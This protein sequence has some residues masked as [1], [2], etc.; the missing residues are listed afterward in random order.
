MSLNVFGSPKSS[1][2]SLSKQLKNEGDTSSSKRGFGTA[3]IWI[4]A[5][6][7]NHSCLGNCRR[8]FIGDM[9]IVRALVDMEE[10]TELRFSYHP[11]T[12]LESYDDV[13]RAL[14]HWGFSCDCALCR[15]RRATPAE[16]IRKR[17]SL[18][19]TLK[20]VL[21]AQNTKLAKASKLL[22]EIKATYPT[23][24]PDELPRLEM[25]SPYFAMSVAYYRKGSIAKAAEMLLE[26]LHALCYNIA[27][28]WR[29]DKTADGE[30]KAQFEIKR[31]GMAMD[32]VPWAFVNLHGIAKSLAPS[33]CPQILE[34]AERAYSMIVGERGSFKQTFP[35][36]M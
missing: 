22:D 3:G 10:G 24:Y 23:S 15:A 31:W 5:S 25:Y 2:D 21:E 4:Q 19:K 1:R 9:Q 6:Y 28:V 36:A 29:H 32:M 17:K 14:K 30:A 18:F 13:Q 11:A 34:Y 33:L 27:V 26:G 8:S 35:T 16:V 20:G 7:V 12:E